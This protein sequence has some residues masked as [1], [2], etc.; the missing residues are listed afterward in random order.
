[1]IRVSAIAHR[2]GRVLYKVAAEKELSRSKDKANH[3]ME[4]NAFDVIFA[5]P[6]ASTRP[7]YLTVRCEEM[8]RRPVFLRQYLEALPNDLSSHRPLRRMLAIMVSS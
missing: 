2:Y 1:M 6:S 8:L 3:Q 5:L 7:T 4:E